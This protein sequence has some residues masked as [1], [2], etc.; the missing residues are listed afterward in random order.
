MN[1]YKLVDALTGEDLCI[2]AAESE[3]AAKRVATAAFPDGHWRIQLSDAP[4]FSVLLNS[5]ALNV[6]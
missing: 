1:Y 5:P 4:D 3:V 6:K 2:I